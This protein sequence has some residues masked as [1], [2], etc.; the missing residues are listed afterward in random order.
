MKS[1]TIVTISKADASI[2]QLSTQPILADQ[3]FVCSAQVVTTGTS[4]G[5]LKLQASNDIVV[6]QSVSGQPIHWFDIT[7]ATV[8]V[9]G[10]GTTAILKTELCYQYIRAVWTHANG[11][12]GT[13]TI[14]LQIAG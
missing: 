1:A 13:I 8:S 12:P 4:T 10:A 11:L 9:V 5:V 2:D 14:N 7:G 6:Q 3:I